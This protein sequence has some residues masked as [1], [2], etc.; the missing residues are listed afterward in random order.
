[1]TKL[2]AILLVLLFMIATTT[3][4]VHS[5]SI[6]LNRTTSQLIKA[7]SLTNENETNKTLNKRSD[8][9]AA[10]GLGLGMTHCVHVAVCLKVVLIFSNFQTFL[11]VF[12]TLALDKLDDLQ[13]FAS[14]KGLGMYLI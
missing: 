8:A 4:R 2:L 7:L 14:D 3:Y 13:S 10:A 12:Q 9:G 6:T 11:G 5:R 1:M